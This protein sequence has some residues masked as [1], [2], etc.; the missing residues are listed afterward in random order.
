LGSESGVEELADED[1]SDN[2]NKGSCEEAEATTANSVI[3]NPRTKPRVLP[4]ID[5]NSGQPVL[6][7]EG[8]QKAP[9][10]SGKKKYSVNNQEKESVKKQEDVTKKSSSRKGWKSNL[11]V[12]LKSI[13]TGFASSNE[14][15]KQKQ[16]SIE[17]IKLNADMKRLDLEKSLLESEER[18]KKEE[19]QYQYNMMQMILS[20]INSRGN[21][22]Q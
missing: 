2:E 16:M 22:Q 9:S 14:A 4:D 13:M 12:E 15:I 3:E 17:E 20:S 11:E 21:R 1:S 5:E 18:Q 10:N 7:K 6:N 8:S 19:K